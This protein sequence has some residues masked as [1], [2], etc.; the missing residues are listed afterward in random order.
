MIQWP[1]QLIT[2]I[3]CRRVVLMI[4]SGISRHS[5]GQNGARPPTWRGFLEAALEQ[6]NP[7]PPHIKKAIQRGQYLDACEWLKKHIDDAWV[8][9]LRQSFVQPKFQAAEI[10]KLLYQLD[11]RIVL[12]PNFDLIYDGY[13]VTDRSKQFSLRTTTTRTSSMVSDVMIG[14]S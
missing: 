14:S 11:C 3:A 9:F 5:V 4:G 1:D 13:A 12:T 8:P 2:D 7:K 10:H 6:C